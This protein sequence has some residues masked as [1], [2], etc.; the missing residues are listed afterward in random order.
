[1]V[2]SKLCK[3]VGR[4]VFLYCSAGKMTIVSELLKIAECIDHFWRQGG[5]LVSVEGEGEG[6]EEGELE[7]GGNNEMCTYDWWSHAPIR[8]DASSANTLSNMTISMTP[9]RYSL[10]AKQ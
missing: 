5:R 9:Q 8:S 2:L 1:M 6:R 7:R 4:N 10:F 3:Y